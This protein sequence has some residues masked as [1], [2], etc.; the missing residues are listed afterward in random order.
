MGEL[1]QACHK[2]DIRLG[3]YLSAGDMKYGCWSTPVPLG[4]RTL[5]GDRDAYLKVYLQQVKELLSNYGKIA[6]LWM[7]GAYN[8]F[9]YDVKNLKTG[10][11]A[12][13]KYSKAIVSLV[14]SLQEDTVVF[15][16]TA[17]LDQFG[18]ETAGPVE[19][20]DRVRSERDGIRA[21]PEE[22]QVMADVETQYIEKAGEVITDRPYQAFFR[23]GSEP[24]SPRG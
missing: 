18:T 11:A 13:I 3:I 10:H 20:A 1:A 23:I 12:G 24:K 22:K 8:P 7:D 21:Y 16:V 5:V 17:E 9:G 4:K 14:H 19:F 15:D 2:H 6:V